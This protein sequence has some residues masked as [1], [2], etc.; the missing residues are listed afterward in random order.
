MAD[1]EYKV[2][3]EIELR[4][5]AAGQASTRLAGHITSLGRRMRM[6]D[7]AAAKLTRSLIAVGATYLGVRAVSRA[8]TGMARGAFQFESAMQ[9]TQL[10]LASMV[11]S[12]EGM[13]F[14]EAGR[15]VDGIWKQLTKIAVKTTATTQE[16]NQIFAGIYGPIRAAGGGMDQIFKMTSNT[17]HAA[18][19]LG[20][21]MSQ[22]TR[23]MMM[24]AQGAAGLDVKLFRS[25]KSAGFITESTKEWNALVPEKR[26]AKLAAVL[27]KFGVAG[28]AA[29]KT[30]S[31]RIS[32]FED[33]Y[34]ILRR[35]FAAPVFKVLADRIGV[36]N[37]YLEKNTG[38]LMSYLDVL[39]YRVGLKLEQVFD[40]MQQGLT[41]VIKNWDLIVNRLTVAVQRMRQL[42]PI[43]AKAAA[44]LLVAGPAMN[45][46]GLG[47]QGVGMLAGGVTSAAGLLGG[48]AAA[49]GAGG[50]GAGAAAAGGA[51]VGAGL[52]AALAPFVAAV[53]IIGSI[54]AAAYDQWSSIKAMFISLSPRLREVG[55][56]FV[57][58]GK[59]LGLNLYN[60]L[61]SI[62]NIV[63]IFAVPAFRGLLVMLELVLPKITAMAEGLAWAFDKIAGGISW[64]TTQVLGLAT[65][66]GQNLEFKENFAAPERFGAFGAMPAATPELGARKRPSM[67]VNQDFRGSRFTIKQEFKDAEPDRVLQ[68]FRTDLMK[69]AERR[70]QSGFAPAI[71]R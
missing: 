2:Y 26:V 62:G 8:F 52:A 32:T 71:A 44:G 38:M 11:S 43:L 16:I 23:D 46:A 54:G 40:K 6:A 42:A 69:Q 24:M 4:T 50:A 9:Q 58:L 21:D 66:T 27:E 37:D 7:T 49:G 53:A 12:I 10:G 5:R 25:M 65:A 3:A 22:A 59:V 14:S 51:A 64:V 60:V 47:V 17:V 33:T 18:N 61:R 57:R 19:A 67:T 15:Q 1:E 13:S 48:G 63:M 34:Q 28:E 35:A 30:L 29:A 20:V 45:I 68:I 31:G 56:M 55:S 39:G 36:M 70:I 41:W